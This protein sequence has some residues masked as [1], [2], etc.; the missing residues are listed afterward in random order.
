MKALN[1]TGQKFGLLTVIQRGPNTKKNESQWYCNCDCGNKNILVRGYYLKNGHTTSCGCI[2]KQYFYKK[3][4]LNKKY[5]KLLVI[6]D[7]NSNTCLCKCECGVVKDIRRQDLLSGNTQ[8]CGC[9]TSRGESVIAQ[10]LLKNNI[11]F[12]QQYY[13]NDFKSEQGKYYRFDFAILDDND[14]VAYLIEFDGKQHF[15]FDTNTKSWNT[16][17]NFLAVK[18]RD[19]IK[20]KYCQEKNIPLIRIPYTKLNTLTFNDLQ[21]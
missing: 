6:D 8:S 12:I 11:K 14:N 20:N 10:I 4:M 7:S 3:D 17:E 19:K 15:G 13:F 16:E 2:K 1:L 9:E 5:G 18:S 21:L